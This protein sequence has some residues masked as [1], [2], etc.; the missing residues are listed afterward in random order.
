MRLSSFTAQVQDV[1][2]RS[3]CA[4]STVYK[5]LSGKP[6]YRYAIETR[7]RVRKACD[8][9]GYVPNSH[10][11]ILA[12]HRTHLL[13]LYAGYAIFGSGTPNIQATINGALEQCHATAY[14][15]LLFGEVRGGPEGLLRAARSRKL[16]GILILNEFHIPPGVMEN[17]RRV[18]APV[19]VME[20]DCP[21]S[22]GLVRIAEERPMEQAVILLAGMGHR[23]LAHFT[24][25]GFFPARDTAFRRACAKSLV[26]GVTVVTARWDTREC[27][28]KTWALMNGPEPPTALIMG[29]ADHAA[30]AVIHALHKAGMRVPGDVS[31]I[32]WDNMP[33]GE[34]AGLSSVAKPFREMGRI[35]VREMVRVLEEP[36]YR[37][38]H[39]TLDAE[40][41]VRDSIGPPAKKIGRGEQ[42]SNARSQ[43]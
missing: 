13:G 32:G 24:P 10:G 27:V 15:L 6:G 7:R 23:R 36:G 11:I 35:G 37:P 26:D 18:G 1:A 8:D 12:T 16:D 9:L 39:A 25:E 38:A 4:K 20:A 14:E 21:G 43:T 41:V 3:G 28:D 22:A 29:T 30:L 17:L 19:L 40:L 31:V 33:F 2:R 42:T 5:I 34:A